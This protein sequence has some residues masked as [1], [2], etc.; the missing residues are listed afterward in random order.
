VIIDSSAGDE[1]VNLTSNPP[2]WLN[3]SIVPVNM[4]F[5]KHNAEAL[6]L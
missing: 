2:S 5:P 1:P 4:V 3:D 6:L